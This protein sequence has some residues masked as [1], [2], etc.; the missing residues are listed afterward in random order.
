MW[1][2][3][4]AAAP[5]AAAVVLPASF[6]PLGLSLLLSAAVLVS[7]RARFLGARRLV[8]S[9]GDRAAADPLAV[10]EF[11]RLAVDPAAVCESDRAAVDPAAVCESDRAAADPAAVGEP[12][13]L[14]VDSAA[15][16]ESDRAAAVPAAVCEPDRL[17]VVPAACE[18]DRLAAEPLAVGEPFPLVVAGLLVVREPCPLAAVDESDPPAAEPT[19]AGRCDLAEASGLARSFLGH[20]RACS[21][22]SMAAHLPAAPNYQQLAEHPDGWR[23]VG[24]YSASQ[25]FPEAPA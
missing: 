20:W 17:A 4:T 5:T 15:V 1:R 16:C 13:R 6:S 22:C 14:A 10:G 11:D 2:S 7:P 24:L 3:E 23:S 8:R 9:V 18:P 19:A 21:P 12:D 25:V